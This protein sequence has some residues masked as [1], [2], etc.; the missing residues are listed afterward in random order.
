MFRGNVER[1]TR[2]VVQGWAARL[3]EPNARVQISIFVDGNK[4]AQAPCAQTSR[5]IAARAR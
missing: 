5:R 4:V 3:D 1:A 2:T